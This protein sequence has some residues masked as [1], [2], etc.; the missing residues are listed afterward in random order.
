[1]A[2]VH[3]LQRRDDGRFGDGSRKEGS[4]ALIHYE[5]MPSFVEGA[6]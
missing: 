2:N 6:T 3:Y 1:M 4:K 5:I